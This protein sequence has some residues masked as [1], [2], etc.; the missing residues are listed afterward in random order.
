M[1][2]YCP[3]NVCSNLRPC[4]LHPE[5]VDQ[6]TKHEG[7]ITEDQITEQVLKRFEECCP[8][9]NPR[10]LTIMTSLTKHLHGFAREVRLTD[11]EWMQGIQFLTAAGKKCDESRQ[12]LI[13]LSD[14]LGLSAVVDVIN[15]SSG[16]E[17]SEPDVLGPF[18]IPNSPQ[19]DYGA[20]MVEFE[21]GGEKAIV[22]GRVLST[23]GEL[24]VGALLD[25]W[26]TAANGFYAVQQPDVQPSGNLRGIYRTDAQGRFKIET[27]RPVPY[28][29]P[30]DGP[31][32]QM[33]TATGRH[34]WRCAHI[35]FKVSA[36]GFVHLISQLFDAES[37]YMDSDAVFSVKGSLIQPFVRQEDGSLRCEYDFV[38]QPTS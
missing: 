4:G 22:T 13:L 8:K 16:G 30:G 5:G 9:S 26:Q 27:V 14:T 20:S 15:H 21:D 23:D 18:Y 38:L 28:Q 32:G 17:A 36:P 31:V 35:H 24:I 12:E 2:V 34:F 1:S 37:K 10:L 25:V 29:I 6:E 3:A 33:L 7:F 11:D 19:R